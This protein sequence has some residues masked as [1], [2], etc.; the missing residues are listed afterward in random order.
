M[1]LGADFKKVTIEQIR[2]RE[3]RLRRIKDQGLIEIAAD[4]NFTDAPA[5]L[6]DAFA[7]KRRAKLANTDEKA[8]D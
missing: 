5:N 2:A 7:A 8:L 3:E 1:P 6:A 4:E